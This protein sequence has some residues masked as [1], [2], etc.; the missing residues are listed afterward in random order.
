MMAYDKEL[1]PDNRLSQSVYHGASS[2]GSLSPDTRSVYSKAVCYTTVL[3]S[4]ILSRIRCFYR[5]EIVRIDKTYS[6][7]FK[8]LLKIILKHNE[9]GNDF[10]LP[11]LQM[12]I[13]SS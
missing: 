2:E 5:L 12:S 8:V 3:C 7:C 1:R 13:L 10:F 11:Q 9:F 6:A 4:E